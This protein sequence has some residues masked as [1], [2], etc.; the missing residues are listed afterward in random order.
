MK[1]PNI[2]VFIEAV[3][4]YPKNIGLKVLYRDYQPK[5][6]D[7]KQRFR[8][9]WDLIVREIKNDRDLQQGAHTD[10]VQGPEGQVRVGI[11]TPEERSQTQNEG[12]NNGGIAE[13][14]QGIKGQ[15]S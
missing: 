3:G 14:S 4:K 5:T 9:S 11:E 10:N 15:E 1:K 13:S 2:R 12:D 6:D 8:E 7:E